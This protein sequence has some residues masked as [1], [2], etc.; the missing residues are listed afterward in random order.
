MDQL[1]EELIS[2]MREVFS[3]FAN[4]TTGTITSRE[5]GTILRCLGQRPTEAELQD[6]INEV[7]LD[8]IGAIDL[9]EFMQLMTRRQRGVDVEEELVEVFKVYDANGNG[10]IGPTEL[11]KA[12]T[13]LGERM[14]NEE[15]GEMLREIDADRDGKVT[16]KDF[17]DSMLG[18]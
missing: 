1:T 4:E 15:L 18:R 7:D 14:T 17:I 3:L 8:G 6:M 10:Q 5:L 16:K 2:E 11:K 12:M 9:S 13:M